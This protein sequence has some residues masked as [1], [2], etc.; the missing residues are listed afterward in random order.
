M[1][2]L[3]NLIAWNSILLTCISKLVIGH[4]TNPALATTTKATKQ[5]KGAGLVHTLAL[6]LTALAKIDRLTYARTTQEV[7]EHHPEPRRVGKSTI[8][9]WD[10]RRA[11]TLVR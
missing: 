9:T 5:I 1:R 11:A 8:C 10:K 3:S 7:K 2:H 6:P 4:V